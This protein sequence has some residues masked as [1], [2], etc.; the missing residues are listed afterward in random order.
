VKD[1]HTGLMHENKLG[2]RIVSAVIVTAV[3]VALVVQAGLIARLGDAMGT[4]LRC[5]VFVGSTRG[6][7]H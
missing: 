3:G 7:H 6:E 1:G 2:I 4:Y 5:A